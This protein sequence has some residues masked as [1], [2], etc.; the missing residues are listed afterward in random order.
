MIKYNETFNGEKFDETF[1]AQNYIGC[2]F[3]NCIFK[4][5]DNMNVE[6]LELFKSD[7]KL[8]GCWYNPILIFTK[9]FDSLNDDINLID[10]I[11]KAFIRSTKDKQIKK[12]KSLV[13]I[14]I[15]V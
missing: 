8:I 10:N 7:N 13:L 15:N 1:K 6:L 9:L 5:V 14:D 11:N 4:D 2:T 3:I 12:Q